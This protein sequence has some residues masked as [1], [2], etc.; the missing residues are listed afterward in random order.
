[1]TD[2]SVSWLLFIGRRKP[3]VS[4]AQARDQLTALTRRMLETAGAHADSAGGGSFA[5]AV[6][7]PISPGARGFSYWRREFASSLYTL[8]V[9]VG[10]VQLIVCANVANLM[11]GRAASRGREI[12]VRLAL[13]AGR[14]RLVQQLVGG[15]PDACRGRRGAGAGGWRTG[16]LPCSCGRCR[17]GAGRAA[18]RCRAPRVGAGVHRRAL[19]VGTALLFGLAPA[20]R[21][22]RVE[23]S[24]VLRAHSRGLTGGWRRFGAGRALV[25]LQVALSLTMLVA[26]GMVLRSLRA[27]ETQDIG[28]DRD[29][30]LIVT[31]SAEQMHRGARWRWSR[32]GTN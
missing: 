30:L 6:G 24:G 11:L 19:A 3:G 28:L 5:R 10:L 31:V 29:H 21:A 14:W 27:L 7:V 15:E 12:G 8:M 26:M 13:G 25:M 16:A 18:H 17:A 1:M 2:R 23:L 4:L 32:C 20:L 22:T 9:V